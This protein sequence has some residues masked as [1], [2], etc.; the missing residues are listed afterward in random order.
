MKLFNIKNTIN[1]KNYVLLIFLGL[2]VSVFLGA[3]TALLTASVGKHYGILLSLPIIILI[4]FIFLIDRYILFFLII[5]FRSAMD[6]ILDATRFGSF[7]LGAVLN[8]LVI[9][10]ALLAIFQKSNIAGKVTS[11]V[12]LPFLIISFFNLAIAPEFLNSI[13]LFLILLSYAAIFSLAITLIKNES[14]YA[15][16]L[17]AVLLSSLIPVVYGFI[18]AATG[19]TL[20]EDGFRIKSTFSHPNVF[21]FYL[22]LMISISFYIYKAKMAFL[23]VFLRRILPLYI[24]LML[25]LLVMTKTRSAWIECF[26]FFTFYALFYERKYLLLIVF[27]PLLGFL[28]PEI[29]DRLLDLGQGN[30]VINYSQLNSYA[31]RKL[32][33]HDGLHWMKPIHYIYGYGLD[34]FKYY[35]T[36]FFTM[37]GKSHSGAHSVYVQ[38]FFETGI[39]GVLAFMWAHLKVAKLLIP[40]HK[41][42]KIMIFS[43]IMFL[44]EYSLAAYSDNMLDY[45]SFNWY[46]WFVLGATYAVNYSKQKTTL[47][48][49]DDYMVQNK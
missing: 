41:I 6:A 4:G 35:S 46:L 2:A 38:L 18:D 43:S 17:R 10:I 3:A 37:A 30:E 19:G 15:R 40:F 42:N 7:G 24:L 31:W 16:W 32:I 48:N 22:V 36:V 39:L 14:D 27:T 45:L 26:A 9:L 23:P 28:I 44:L 13:K 20:G 34:S 33:W 8:A 49:A 12:W 47:I 25:A 5:I 1:K 21:A 11:Q 29:R